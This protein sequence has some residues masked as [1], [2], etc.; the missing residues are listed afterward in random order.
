[1]NYKS[2]SLSLHFY[3]GSCTLAHSGA[4][5][6]IST[7]FTFT[8]GMSPYPRLSS[9]PLLILSDKSDLSMRSVS[10]SSPFPVGRAPSFGRSRPLVGASMPA[11]A[12]H[13]ALPPH[14][15]QCALEAPQWLS[16]SAAA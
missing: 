13:I 15:R 4:L 16:L 2:S 11:E 5:S 6:I 14:A 1:M 10:W 7:T 9:A 12:H 8:G 3:G